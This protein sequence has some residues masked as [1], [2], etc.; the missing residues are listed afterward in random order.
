[1]ASPATIKAS[2]AQVAA[3]LWALPRPGHEQEQHAMSTTAKGVRSATGLAPGHS[4]KQVAAYLRVG[5]AKVL[6][7]IRGG[8]LRALD[9]GHQG[10]CGGRFVILP[11]D[12]AAFAATLAVTPTPP[13]RPRRRSRRP[14]A[15]KDYFPD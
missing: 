14:A 7:W 12:L 1:M 10:P 9:T 11:A 13:P 5:K 2:Q 15:T 8:R 3:P 4:V 6:D